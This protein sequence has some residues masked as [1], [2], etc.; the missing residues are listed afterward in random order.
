MKT[1]L[2]PSQLADVDAAIRSAGLE[3][4]D[5][6]WLTGSGEWAGTSE[7]VPTLRHKSQEWWCK[8]AE[9]P[10]W[11]KS[12]RVLDGGRLF[13]T[14]QICPSTSRRFEVFQREDWQDAMGAVRAW[15][16]Y[17]RR[18]LGMPHLSSM[19]AV[20]NIA[21]TT[22]RSRK[23][24]LI[25]G[26]DEANKLRVRALLRERYALET[27]ILGDLPGTGRT[28]IEKFEEEAASCGFAVALLTP[29]DVVNT[30]DLQYSQPRPN[31]VFELGWFFGRL[32]RHG[33]LI[34]L[35][36]DVRLHS[37]LD[38]ISRVQFRESVDETIPQLEVELRAAKLIA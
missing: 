11:S 6:Q 14:L 28:L 33:S 24:F 30:A 19:S 36:H 8:F 34:L 2:L 12:G 25:H 23:V 17:V 38:G 20:D 10:K 18:E 37:D 1:H 9:A 31:V 22:S 15:L 16:G 29:D 21:D 27:V 5:F 4:S 26:H 32:G 35:K 3:A 7:D 13:H